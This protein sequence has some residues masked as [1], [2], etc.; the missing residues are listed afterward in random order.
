MNK[1][2]SIS[3]ITACYNSENSIEN[4]ILSVLSQSKTDFEY[5]I[6]DGASTDRTLYIIENYRNKFEEQEISFKLLSERDKGIG[7]A[8]NKGLHI[9][10]GDVIGLLNADDQY[11]P[12]T[13]EIILKRIRKDN[14]PK[15]FYGICKFIK[16]HQIFGVNDSLFNNKNLLRGF[17]FTHTTCFVSKEVYQQIGLFNTE[18][19][20]AVDTEFLIK[21]YLADIGFE[22]LENI[23]YMN[24]GG[25]SDLQ[26]KK[27]YFE[28]LEILRRKNIVSL[29]KIKRQKILYSIYFPFRKIFKS[30]YLRSF[31]RQ[32][33]HYSV[34][35]FNFIYYLLPTFYLKNLFLNLIGIKVDRK[36]YIHPKVIFYSWKNL[37]IKSNSVIN[38]GCRIDNRRKISIGENVS[39]AHNTQIYT[40]GHDINSPYFDMIGKEVV[41]EDYVCIFSNC[42]IMP[43]VKIGRG[44]VIYAGSVVT[45]DVAPYNVVG[46]NPAV[47]IKYRNSNLS[48]NI[49]YGYHKAL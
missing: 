12:Y 49:D 35:I 14:S 36:S 27:A 9:A 43:G 13:I 33:K 34:F 32:S 16:D 4:T 25:V 1:K 29:K 44:A 38:A 39:I 37:T 7:D 46:G 41:I 24:L 42:L 47:F 8:W 26:A 45:K 17:G 30:T 3:I 40:C 5:I 22:R 10:R 18:V 15:V 48:Y 20:I 11:H 28:Y 6:I 21:C 31:L 19:K 2:I 23:T